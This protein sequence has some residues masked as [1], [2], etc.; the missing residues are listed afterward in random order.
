MLN[1]NITLV[2][3]VTNP[4]KHTAIEVQGLYITLS[5]IARCEVLATTS[6]PPFTVKKL[7]HLFDNAPIVGTR[8]SI[9]PN[10]LQMIREEF[11]RDFLYFN[12]GGKFGLYQRERRRGKDFASSNVRNSHFKAIMQELNCNMRISYLR[13]RKSELPTH[14][15]DLA[16]LKWPICII[17]GTVEHYRPLITNQRPGYSHVIMSFHECR[18][19]V[20]DDVHIPLPGWVTEIGQSNGDMFFTDREGICNFEC[21]TWGISKERVLRGWY[22]RERLSLLQHQPPPAASILKSSSIHS[23]SQTLS[24]IITNLDLKIGGDG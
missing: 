21:L 14:A 6:F 18:G 11:E 7:D 2:V 4:S 17:T 24:Y 22:Q 10:H 23:S 16:L 3:I 15:M 9:Q 20:G 1:E 13:D 5:H 12:L 19:N 8:L